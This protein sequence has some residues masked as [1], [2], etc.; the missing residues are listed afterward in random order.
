M[1][2]AVG[3][4]QIDIGAGARYFYKSTGDPIAIVLRDEN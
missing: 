2:R 3:H 4:R 1:K